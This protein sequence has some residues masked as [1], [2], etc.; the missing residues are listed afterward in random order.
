MQR[1]T[2]G[3]RRSAEDIRA[4][5]TAYGELVQNVSR[6]RGAVSDI[7]DLADRQ[8]DAASA[9][10]NFI[11]GVVE[12]AEHSKV[13]SLHSVSVGTELDEISTQVS[14]LARRFES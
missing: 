8:H 5:G 1:Q 14:E 13:R 7:A 4:A 11:S 6:I 3:A 2:T 12:S 10:K 9:V